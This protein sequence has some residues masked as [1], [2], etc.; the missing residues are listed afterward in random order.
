MPV[1]LEHLNTVAD[2]DAFLKKEGVKILQ[3]TA[4]W[5]AKCDTIKTEL[6]E[7]LESDVH[8]GAVDVDALSEIADRFSVTALPRVD[9]ISA[10]RSITDG[11]PV[12]TL[13]AFAC[14][15]DAVVELVDAV[16]VPKLILDEDF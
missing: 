16:K 7:K 15:S 3:F 13:A 2:V 14:N 11:A 6:E 10:T 8:Y 1:T 12:T 4:E 9:I 5:C